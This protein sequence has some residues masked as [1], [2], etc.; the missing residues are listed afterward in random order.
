MSFICWINRFHKI[1]KNVLNF[2]ILSLPLNYRCVK[3]KGN[4]FETFLYYN[5]VKQVKGVIDIIKVKRSNI[6][7]IYWQKTQIQY[8][9]PKTD[10]DVLKR[11]LYLLQTSCNLQMI[12]LMM[13]YTHLKR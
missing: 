5:Y 9:M 1:K 7:Y 13:E 6:R 2:G 10:A 4:T 11:I 8:Q 3:F 12:S